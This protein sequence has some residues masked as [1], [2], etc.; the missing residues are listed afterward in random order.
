VDVLTTTCPSS[1]PS[2]G[3][4]HAD[5]W[6]DLAPGEIRHHVAAK[7]TIAAT[8][9][10]F[11]ATFGSTSGG[12]CGTSSATDN[13]A[14]ANYR[15]APAPSPGYTMA[16]SATVI[17]NF[18]VTGVND[19]VAARL[20][21][22]DPATDTQRLVARGL[23]RPE[24]GDESVRQVFQ[25]HPQAYKVEPGHVLKLELLPND[26][27]YARANPTSPDAAAQHPVVVKNLQLRLP[28]LESPGALD[29]LVETP[30]P[31]FVPDGY[32]LARDFRPG[33]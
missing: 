7:R 29:G 17:A 4:F 19:Q 6:A 22:V 27:P 12:P 24:V 15:L 10:Q 13:P 2:A 3:P 11:G 5:N 33:N 9:T 1:S 31:K 23:W 32:E 21:D 30:L 25:L 28:V 26:A 8:G 18:T 16:G 20:L 14:T